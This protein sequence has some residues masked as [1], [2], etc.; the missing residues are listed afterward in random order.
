[1][2]TAGVVLAVT[3]I[4]MLLLVAFAGTAQAALLVMVQVTASPLLRVL[5][6]KAAL[7]VPAAAPFTSHW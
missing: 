5:V 2:L 7:L 6:V 3:T 1:M 4:F